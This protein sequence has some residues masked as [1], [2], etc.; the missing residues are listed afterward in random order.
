MEAHG[1]LALKSATSALLRPVMDDDYDKPQ[2]WYG[3][4]EQ[5]VFWRI[6]SITAWQQ[7]DRRIDECVLY[8]K[9]QDSRCSILYFGYRLYE[10]L[11]SFHHANAIAGSQGRL[12]RFVDHLA[13]RAIRWPTGGEMESFAYWVGKLPPPPRARFSRAV[14]RGEYMDDHEYMDDR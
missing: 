12:Q 14:E 8:W 6:T 13:K 3:G 4:P 7:I 11:W 1:L 9:A 2:T 5:L 10:I